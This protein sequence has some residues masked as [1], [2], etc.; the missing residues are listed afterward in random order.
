[1]KKDASREKVKISR[2]KRPADSTS[3]AC[4]VPQQQLAKK[5]TFKQG[6]L[7]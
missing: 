7:A 3:R 6:G 4:P 2:Q 5:K 1:M